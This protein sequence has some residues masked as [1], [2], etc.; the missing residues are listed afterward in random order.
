[1]TKGFA[2]ILLPHGIVVNGLAP[3][4]TATEMVKDTSTDNIYYEHQPSHRYATPEEIANLAL[5]MISPMGN[6]IVGDTFYMT[7][8]S[9]TISYHR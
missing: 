3:G 6:M 5:F 1:M 8:G 2:D 7:G 4:P 9:G